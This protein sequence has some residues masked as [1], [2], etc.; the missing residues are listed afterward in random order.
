MKNLNYFLLCVWLLLLCSN[1]ALFSQ[2]PPEPWT[3]LEYPPIRGNYDGYRLITGKNEK[4]ILQKLNLELC[5]EGGVLIDIKTTGHLYLDQAKGGKEE[6]IQFTGYTIE[7]GGVRV[8]YYKVKE[9]RDEKGELYVLYEVSKRDDFTPYYPIYK[10]VDNYDKKMAFVLSFIPFGTPQFYKGNRGWGTFFLVSETLALIGTGMSLYMSN[11]YYDDF[12]KERNPEQRDE[13]KRLSQ[14]FETLCY[15]SAGIAGSLYL[16]GILH[17][18]FAE[19]KYKKYELAL[20][21]FATQ[22]NK[23]IMATFKF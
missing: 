7:C 21:P 3:K 6:N 15:I 12:N 17:G 13:Y 4:E 9:H 14:N 19:G 1:C 20:L 11:S 2:K 8:W 22:E 23:G 16:S 10:L 5:N 18:L